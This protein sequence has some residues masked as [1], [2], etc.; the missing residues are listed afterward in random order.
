MCIFPRFL[1]RQLLIC[2]SGCGPLGLLILAV[3]KAYGVRKVVMF[4]VEQSRV[5]FAIKYGADV[6][7]VPPKKEESVESLAYAQDYASKIIKEHGLGNGFDVSVEASGAEICAQMA[8]CVL[9]N[10]G[11]CELT[12]VFSPTA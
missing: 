11:T 5:D 10:G 8:I 7:I 2:T 3:A 12:S 6:G 1:K 9:K 4:D